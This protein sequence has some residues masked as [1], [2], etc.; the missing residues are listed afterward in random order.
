[1][2]NTVLYINIRS[3]NSEKVDSNSSVVTPQKRKYFVKQIPTLFVVLFFL[4]IWN[5]QSKLQLCY[6]MA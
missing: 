3:L 4:I 5:V 2:R 1:M 6:C